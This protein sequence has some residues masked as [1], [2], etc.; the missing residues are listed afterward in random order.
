MKLQWSFPRTVVAG[1]LVTWGSIG[2]TKN[3]RAAAEVRG[4]PEASGHRELP[5][6]YDVEEGADIS[7]FWVLTPMSRKSL[8]ELIDELPDPK[9]DSGSIP[10]SSKDVGLRTCIIAFGYGFE[11]AFGLRDHEGNTSDI[12]TGLMDNYPLGYGAGANTLLIFSWELNKPDDPPE[13]LFSPRNNPIKEA[14][15][16][17]DIRYFP[18]PS[19][20]AYKRFY[21]LKRGK[22]FRLQRK[23]TFEGL[24]KT[25]VLEWKNL[26]EPDL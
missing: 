13:T 24:D 17:L 15:K 7:G 1:L 11:R 26:N 16:W 14:R 23:F 10:M 8:G 21:L 4:E 3:Q 12:R 20:A 19:M 18:Q 22:Y 9:P 6:I 25:I 2:C 5:P